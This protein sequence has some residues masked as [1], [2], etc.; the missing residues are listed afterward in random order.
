VSNG[1]DN[2]Q[3]FDPDEFMRQR[4]SGATA[5]AF[6]PDEFMANRKQLLAGSYQARK[7]GP[8]LNANESAYREGLHGIERGLGM[9]PRDIAEAPSF[10]S[11]LGTGFKQMGQSAWDMVKS[12]TGKYFDKYP[13]LSRPEMSLLYPFHM[14]ARG[15]E[16]LASGAEEAASDIEAGI[17][18]RDLR[19]AAAGLGGAAALRGQMELAEKG[20]ELANRTLL[21]PGAQ[22]LGRATKAAGEPFGIGVPGEELLKKG[23]SPRASAVGWD[24]AVE[25]AQQDLGNYH[26]FNPI[27]SVSDL[28]EAIPKIQQGIMDGE[29]KPVVAKHANEPLAPDRMARVS[30]AVRDSVGP[31]AQ[32]FD[33]TAAEAAKDLA[34]KMTR[35]RTIGDLMGGQRGGLLGYIN[36]KLDS[37][38][39]KYPSARGTDLM[40]NPETAMWEAAR[41]S[42][43]EEALD[44]LE[45]AGE[46]GIR[47]ARQRWGAL[48][49]IQKEVER[50]VNVAERQKPIGLYRMLGAITALPTAG[51]GLALGE[52]ANYLNKP[53]VLVRRG[54]SRMGSPA[55][56]NTPKLLGRPQSPVPLALLGRKRPE[57]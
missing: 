55:T 46:T 22:L 48:E 38:F 3:T 23:V 6:D 8:V 45:Q 17:R 9:N 7:G 32:E 4:Q 43:R 27:E 35:V 16:G 57:E 18:N 1:T 11:A 12:E 41:R 36:A 42:L 14:A 19:S 10:G 33:P 31:F 51:V 28:N 15:A 40:R 49:E 2:P 34:N 13:P 54:L 29:V 5:A 50:R 24:R 37:Y 47:E 25:R 44:H 53:D 20:G 30:Q 26:K 21:R 56:A 52:T 39:A